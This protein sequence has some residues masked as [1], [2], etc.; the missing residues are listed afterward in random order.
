M[1]QAHGIGIL[2]RRMVLVLLLFTASGCTLFIEE[3]VEE[4]PVVVVA[5]PE[6]EP[7]APEPEPPVEPPPPKPEPAPMEPVK[8]PLRVAVLLSD[9]TPAYENVALELENRL[10][11]L[12]L[13]DL[14]DKS[15]T[16]ED[17]FFA[18]EAHDTDV[19]VAIGLR[20]AKIAKARSTVPVVFSQVFNATQ[21]QLL[22]DDV[23]GVAVIPPLD[24]QIREWKKIDPELETIGAI[25]GTGHERLI[26]EAML[27]TEANDVRFRYEVATSDRET[28]YLFNRLAPGV[29]GYW[30][31]PD[32]RIL[33]VPV[34]RQML[35]EA[36]KH[37][38]QVTVF[39]ESLLQL[40][41]VFSATAVNS[42]IAAVIVDVMN[43]ISEEGSD[44]LPPISPLTEISITT[45]DAVIRRM[46]LASAD[47]TASR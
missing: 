7:P 24:M 20:A 44:A 6:P 10:D 37:S 19:V 18:V 23:K 36:A 9:R 5:E 34:L 25:I 12:A 30:L 15:L 16:P 2:I 39:N 42:D 41:A 28:L 47:A 3:P 27:A 8:K 11:D 33:S 35:R 14:T 22:S 38:V 4:P 32:N 46:K 21:H 43:R 26:S 29:D 45:N 17:I 40:G 13:F 1:D 31:F